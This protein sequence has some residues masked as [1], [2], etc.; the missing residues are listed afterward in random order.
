MKMTK[1]PNA[2]EI[3]RRWWVV[4]GEGVPVGRLSTR[5]AR[6]I[7]GKGKP[8]WAPHVDCGDFVIVVNA[9]KVVLTGGKDRGKVYHRHTTQKPGSRVHGRIRWMSPTPSM[10]PSPKSHPTTRSSSWSGVHIHVTSGTPL[11][12]SQTGVSSTASRA[13]AWADEGGTGVDT[14]RTPAIRRAP[15]RSGI[16]PRPR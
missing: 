13:A 4:N 15:S 9:G 3:D 11:T 8:N 12:S 7:L 6:L 2:A 14:A 5:V 16:R 1:S 10:Y